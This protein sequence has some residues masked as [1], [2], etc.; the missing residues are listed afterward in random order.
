MDPALEEAIRLQP[1][2]REIEA[3]AVIAKGRDPPEGLRV[4]ASFGEVVTCRVQVGRLRE[5]R[6]HPAVLSLKAARLA[7]PSL[8]SPSVGIAASGR[9]DGRTTPERRGSVERSRQRPRPVAALMDW[10]LDFAH[11]NFRFAD[12]STRLLALW[13]QRGSSRPDSPAPY[14]YGR[15]FDRARLN[16][17]LRAQ[18]PYADLR[19]D[20][21][22]AD[23]QGNGSHGTATADILAGNGR[24]AGTVPAEVPDCGLIFVH[25]ATGLI[26]EP[27]GDLA[28]SVRILEALDF[29]R[30]SIVREVVISASVGRTGGEHAGK[31]IFDLA[32]NAVLEE[33]PGRAF[34][35]SAGNYYDKQMHAEGIVRPARTEH[36]E[37]I[38]GSI[39]NEAELEIWYSHKDRLTFE[40]T[41]PDGEVRIALGLGARSPITWRHRVVGYAYHRD[42][43]SLAL[44]HH[45]D[46]FIR[47]GAPEGAW[48]VG[49]TG[50]DVVDGR[51]HAWIER[52]SGTGTSQSRFAATDASPRATLGTLATNDRSLVCGAL[53]PSTGEVAP[54]SSSGPT[55]DGRPKPDLVAPG[56][57]VPVARSTPAGLP[58][59]TGGA[60]RMSGTSMAA[61]RVAAAVLRIFFEAKRKLNIAETRALLLGTARP[62]PRSDPM[63]TGSGALDSD[64]A[65]RAVR[66]MFEREETPMT[67]KPAESSSG[68]SCTPTGRAD[69]GASVWFESALSTE[70]GENPSDYQIVGWPGQALQAEIRSG[71]LLIRVSPGESLRPVVCR[72]AS[73]RLYS[74]AELTS[75]GLPAEAGGPGWYVEAEEATRRPWG[76]QPRMRRVVGY[77]R[78]LPA[79]QMVVRR[80]SFPPVATI[81][82]API[83]ARISEPGRA[84]P[85]MAEPELPEPFE[86]TEPTEPPEPPAEPAVWGGVGGSVEEPPSEPTL[87]GGDDETAEGS[88]GKLARARDVATRVERY[89]DP[90]VPFGVALAICENESDFVPGAGDLTRAYGLWQIM[91]LYYAAYGLSSKGER[92][93]PERSTRGVMRTMGRNARRIDTLAPDLDPDDRAGLVYYAHAEGM[94]RLSGVIRNVV[95]RGQ[96]VTLATV[97]AARKPA[98]RREGFLTVADRWREWEAAKDALLSGADPANADVLLLSRNARTARAVERRALPTEW[99]GVG[100]DERRA[101]PDEAETVEF[102]DEAHTEADAAPEEDGAPQDLALRADPPATIPEPE[103]FAFSEEG[104]TGEAIEDLEE[105]TD[106]DRAEDEEDEPQGWS[107]DPELVESWEDHGGFESGTLSTNADKGEKPVTVRAFRFRG[108]TDQVALVFSGIHGNEPQGVSLAKEIAKRLQRAAPAKRPRFTTIVI[109]ELFAPSRQVKGDERYVKDAVTGKKVEPNRNFPRPGESYA[110]AR[111]RGKKRELLGCDD[112]ALAGHVLIPHMLPETRILLQLIERTRPARAASLHAHIRKRVRGDDPGIFVDPRGGVNEHTDQAWT[113]QGRKDDATTFALLTDALE[114]LKGRLPLKAKGGATLPHP[115]TGNLLD[116]DGKMTPRTPPTVHY[117]SS[118][119]PCGTS[120]G[121]WAPVPEHGGLRPALCTVTVELPKYENAPAAMQD[122]FDAHATV[123]TQK[124]LGLPP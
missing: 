88:G 72:L 73:G 19:Y 111:R 58:A 20:P 53:D 21:S 31:S 35:Q 59:G 106:L 12:G 71:D 34:V 104:G 91:P 18:S 3:A 117:T 36:L 37:W 56:V 38:V 102:L 101:G 57:N 43:D 63:R 32:V 120:F 114:H 107:L 87:G 55:R 11:P 52:A 83:Q 17:A 40:L 51:F 76:T 75:I 78:Y 109:P 66:L 93:D 99:E 10:G 119:H 108:M 97:L 6:R 112:L 113:A 69:A 41:S 14:G 5:I 42:S 62:V 96:P 29:I 47:S 80:R 16:R 100:D 123:L 7:Q 8:V 81:R 77:H 15:V 116:R 25:L 64:A 118:K 103:A 115:F 26:E 67:F 46:C 84:E 28:D 30:K 33:A 27:G 50:T 61:P 70:A 122:V 48:K 39:E 110:Y 65:V 98:N 23:R 82:A 85:T 90:A 2:E 74:H 94:P 45:I 60:T 44:D 95:A 92:G 9:A 1:R 105:A 89:R 24:A 86:P 124:Y 4:I 49:L 54:F 22:D 121:M 68:S 13:D 79:N